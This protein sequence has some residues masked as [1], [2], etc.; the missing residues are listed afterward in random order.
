[1]G[2]GRSAETK[3]EGKKNPASPGQVRG[4][5]SRMASEKESRVWARVRVKKKPVAKG[6]INNEAARGGGSRGITSIT[7]RY[8]RGA[9]SGRR[10]KKSFWVIKN[11]HHSAFSSEDP[12]PSSVKATAPTEWQEGFQVRS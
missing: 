4:E 2:G 7:F 1:V 5:G 10:G 6:I 3:R 12:E 8:H 11:A 9:H